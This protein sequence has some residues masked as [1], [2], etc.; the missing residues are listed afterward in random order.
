[1]TARLNDDLSETLKSVRTRPLLVMRLDVPPLV[2]V[3][4]TPGAKRR[5]GLV[6]GGVFEGDRLCGEV[7]DKGSDWQS[8]CQDGATTLDARVVLK[9]KDDALICMTYRGPRHGP[10]DVMERIARGETVDPAAYYFR[11]SPLFETAAEKY[12][13]SNRVL[14]V[15]VGHRRNDGPVCSIFEV[16]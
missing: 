2:I 16:L 9:T 14:A 5:I 4:A 13:W 15:G 8:V 6:A 12:D 7:M 11:I 3:G 10:P 1:M